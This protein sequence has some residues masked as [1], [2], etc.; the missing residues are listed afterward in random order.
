MILLIGNKQRIAY[1]VE[2]IV[3]RKKL[4]AK[5]YSLNA[6][7]GFTLI[8]VMISVA[9]LS[10]G[11]VLILQGFASCLSA[12]RVSENNLKA[13]FVVENKI[14]EAEIIAKEDWDE[15]E[16]GIRDRFECKGMQCLWEIETS[17]IE[18]GIE[19]VPESCEDL[20]RVEASLFWEEG[21]RKGRVLLTTYMREH[22]ET[23]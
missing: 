12:L 4:S 11:L 17:P 13:T 22:S 6:K 15:L 21:K 9:I 8:E 19:E 14:A 3:Y 23:E 7:Q 5:R 16:G 20:R 2:R 18:W 10:V 1:N